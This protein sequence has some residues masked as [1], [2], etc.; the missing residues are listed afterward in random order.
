VKGE[1]LM[2]VAAVILIIFGFGLLCGYF[3]GKSCVF[4]N[5][6]EGVPRDALRDNYKSN[7]TFEGRIIFNGRSIEDIKLLPN[8]TKKN[9]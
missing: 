7:Y 6:S 2:D 5:L 3:L 9:E 1:I 4:S 8:S